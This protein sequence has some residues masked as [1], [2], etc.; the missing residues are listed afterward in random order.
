MTLKVEWPPLPGQ[1]APATPALSS[2]PVIPDDWRPLDLAPILAGGHVDPAPSL[3][4]RTDGAGLVY[5][6]KLHSFAGESESLKSWLLQ[7][8][9]V[10]ELGAGGRVL[11]LDYEDSAPSVVGRLLALRCSPESILAGFRYLRPAGP[12]GPVRDAILAA[13]LT[14]GA[15]LV[16]LDGV[17][18]A[19]ALLGL[20]PDANADVARFLTELVRPLTAGGAGVALIDHVTKARESRGRYA[21]GAQHKLA[22]LD[23]AGYTVDLLAPFGHGRHG[24]AR[25]T[26]SKDRP[27][28]VREHCPGQVAGEL[29]LRSQPD[30]SILAEIAPPVGASGEPF[31][32]T[33]LMGRVSAALE[34]SPA[35][36][37]VRGIADVV[38]GKATGV[39]LATQVLIA[40]GFV[41]VEQAG[42][43]RL[44]YS[45]RPFR[46]DL[47]G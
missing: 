4:T 42:Q 39:R 37:S 44:H 16:V 17:T 15:T 20:D 45:V 40:E 47:D 24:I 2:G 38:A 31:R 14:E 18:E 26:V 29:H 32:P 5:P 11:W 46:E 25:L 13:L 8:A 1:P 30:G 9:A 34:G 35:G 43:S 12:L 23:G 19:M 36:L 3:L 21:I 22:G 28:R 10:E 27:G 41:R 6:G 33:V 7:L